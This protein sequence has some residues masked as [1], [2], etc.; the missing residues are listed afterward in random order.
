MWCHDVILASGMVMVVVIRTWAARVILLR[1]GNWW[2]IG[3]STLKGFLYAN[4]NYVHKCDPAVIILALASF[5][6]RSDRMLTTSQDVDR[7]WS[8]TRSVRALR[9]LCTALRLSVFAWLR[10]VLCGARRGE[11][12]HCVNPA[13][14]S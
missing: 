9:E 13:R 1:S 5:A 3:L 2:L 8:K 6:R 12:E 4:I 7:A 11:V 14:H 10:G